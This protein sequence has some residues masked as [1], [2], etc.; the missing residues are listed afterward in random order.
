[1]N[2][3]KTD[4]IVEMVVNRFSE[5]YL[6]GNEEKFMGKINSLID[7][8]IRLAILDKVQHCN[9]DD[10]FARMIYDYLGDK[11]GENPSEMLINSMTK[12]LLNNFTGRIYSKKVYGS[13]CSEEKIV[14]FDDMQEEI[15][16]RILDNFAESQTKTISNSIFKEC[17]SK[18]FD[19]LSKE[20][21]RKIVEQLNKVQVVKA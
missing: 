3:K 6:E 18:E 15:V 8:K 9:F 7:D 16:K 5:L 19:D 1:M 17:L 11:T 10:F 4:E 14:I 13:S 20:N 21:I 2:Q 12:S